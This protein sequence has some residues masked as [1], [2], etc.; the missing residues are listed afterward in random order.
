MLE[1]IKKFFIYGLAS[2]LGKMIAVFLMPIYTDIFSVEEYGVMAVIM[3]CKGIIDLI[4]NLNIHS[5]VARDYYEVG[6][7][8]YKLISTGFGVLYVVLL[9]F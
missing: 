5:G 4:S 7:D 9:L 6:K 3:G 2:I 8:K 1:F